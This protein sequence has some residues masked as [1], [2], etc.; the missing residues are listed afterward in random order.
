[1]PRIIA[2]LLSVVGCTGVRTPV[3]PETGQI[4]RSMQEER[5][6]FIDRAEALDRIGAHLEASFY[7]EAAL[8]GGGDEQRLLPCLIGVLVRANRLRAARMYLNRLEQLVP[9]NQNL[10]ELR[11]LLARFA[12]QKNVPG[13][14]EVTP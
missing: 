7:L 14:L 3:G 8:A 2:V 12:P 6:V 13:T 11:G 10:T 5:E 1:M 4:V 9:E